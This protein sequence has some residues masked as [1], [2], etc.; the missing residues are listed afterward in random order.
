[1]SVDPLDETVDIDAL[2]MERVLDNK[3]LARLQTIGPLEF[4][5]LTPSERRVLAARADRFAK[6]FGEI[7]NWMRAAAPR[8]IQPPLFLVDGYE[9]GAVRIVK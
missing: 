7:A 8:E 3:W 1:M 9:P 5:T 2:A 6:R 4:G